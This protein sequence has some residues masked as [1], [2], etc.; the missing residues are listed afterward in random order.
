MTNVDAK[1]INKR[2]NKYPE[3]P[4]NIYD[5]LRDEQSHEAWYYPSYTV[6]IAIAR[7]P[8][9]KIYEI[10]IPSIILALFQ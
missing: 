3:S 8:M 5:L 4:A 1:P 2:D 9:N 6:E 7:E 10:F